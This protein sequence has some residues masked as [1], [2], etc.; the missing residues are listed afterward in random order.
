MGFAVER[1]L[2]RVLRR[3]PGHL[4]IGESALEII[5]FPKRNFWRTSGVLLPLPAPLFYC[6]VDV[7]GIF[8][9]L[10]LGGGQGG[11]RGAGGGGAIF[12]GKSQE[13]GGSPRWVGAG[14]RGAGGCLR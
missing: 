13:G 5:Q 2:R 6:L 4:Q 7:S 3:G 1:V 11:V 14:E 9:F 8:Y 10:L 12:C